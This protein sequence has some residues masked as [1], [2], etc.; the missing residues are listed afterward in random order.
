MEKLFTK[1]MMAT[2]L[3]FVGINGTMN[4]AE[5]EIP[6]VPDRVFI[7]DFEIAPGETKLVEVWLESTVSWDMMFAKFELPE[8]LEFVPID[9][10]ELPD[11]Y[12]FEPVDG[13]S[14]MIALS[15]NFTNQEYWDPAQVNLY[16]NRPNIYSKYGCKIYY[17]P[18]PAL[19]IVSELADFTFNTTLQIALMKVRASEGLASESTLTMY[20]SF[21]WT[22]QGGVV[23]AQEKVQ[24]QGPATVA[25]I[26]RVNGLTAVDDIRVADTGDGLYYDM[27][28]RAMT[29]PAGAGIYVRNG[30][31]IV[32]R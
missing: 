18:D 16:N 23:G 10:E 27:Q 13:D 25:H 19:M 2:A 3:C 20:Q 8:G 7:E 24:V 32:V 12:T 11:T 15:T 30:K 5:S 26:K 29:E 31:K 6:T 28:G 9:A 1:I 14:K 21:F 22:P 4:A 17:S